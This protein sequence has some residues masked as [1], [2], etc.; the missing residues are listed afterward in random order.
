MHLVQG[1]LLAL[2]Q[3]ARTGK[4]QQVN[5][6][7]Y[8]SML[9]MQM[10]EASMW[11]MRDR[12]FSW[13]AMPFTGSFDTSDGG[14]VIVGAFKANPLR[15]ISLA[16]GL[17]DL[18]ADPRFATF[19]IAVTNRNE[20]HA[21]LRARIATNST[22]HWIA[23][24]EARDLLC[25]PIQRLGDALNDPQTTENEMILRDGDD[26]AAVG[27]PIHLSGGGF[28]FRH[29]P[30]TLGGDGKAV[31]AEFGYTPTEIERLAETGVL[32]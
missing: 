12:D 29:R 32:S 15:E 18:S 9:A 1:I 24:L 23:A 17:E 26:F 3:R 13:G 20:L 19:E 16:L 31:L 11:L 6:S 30:P 7:L 25:S 27:T 28:A 8:D 21:I 14:I 22:A 2:L 5:V 4:G 10:Q